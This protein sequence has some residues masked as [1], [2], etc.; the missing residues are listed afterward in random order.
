VLLVSHY[1]EPGDVDDVLAAADAIGDRLAGVLFN[2]VSSSAFDE[3]A[4]DV[5]PFLAE[6]GV[7]T[8]G[9]L[10][11]DETLAGVTVGELAD[12]LGAE[13]LTP[14]ASTDQ[15][16]E[17][18]LVGAMSSRGA[19]EQFRRTRNGAVITGSDRS[20][21]QRTALEA[22]G[23]ACLVLTGGYQPSKTILGT[24]ASH[25]V[26]V[27]LVRSDT[28]TTID[29]VEAVLRSGRTQRRETVERMAELLE[30]NVDVDRVLETDG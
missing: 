13:Q 11:H 20:D 3:V 1:E 27:L 15:R 17:R 19:L 7:E 6:R 30:A 21:I 5:V 23:V 29:R 10:P 14:E 12:E 16:I 2:Q 8:V 22:S 18:F 9:I 24:A 28:R 25:D 26:P 4:D